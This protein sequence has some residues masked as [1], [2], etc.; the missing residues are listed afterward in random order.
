[1][2][3]KNPGFE[4]QETDIPIGERRRM[5]EILRD[6]WVHEK[7]DIHHSFLVVVSD[8]NRESLVDRYNEL[9]EPEFALRPDQ[10]EF[11]FR[12]NGGGHV[13]GGD[14]TM[15]VG[16][17]SE[18]R[19][20][21]RVGMGEVLESWSFPVKCENHYRNAEGEN[22]SGD[23][24]RGDDVHLFR[25]EDLDD[26]QLHAATKY[27]DWEELQKQAVKHGYVEAKGK[28]KSGTSKKRADNAPA[29]TI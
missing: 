6:A 9:V 21:P 19:N 8:E 12:N 23:I 13:L 15:L 28:A 22:V 11:I 27:F 18:H 14:E 24:S 17:P 26:N 4:P 2:A 20:N 29:Q 25:A 7:C 16:P 1:M 10:A 5:L 3:N